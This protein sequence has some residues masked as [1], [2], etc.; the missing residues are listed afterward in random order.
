MQSSAGSPTPPLGALENL[1]NMTGI[2]FESR[3]V[4]FTVIVQKIIVLGLP[5]RYKR[6]GGNRR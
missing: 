1:P 3:H 6:G 4:K 5:N 2:D